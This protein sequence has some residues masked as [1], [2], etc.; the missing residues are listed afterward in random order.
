M[1]SSLATIVLMPAAA[2]ALVIIDKMFCSLN[3][4]V[5]NKLKAAPAA[6]TYCSSYLS[7]STQTKTSTVYVT[8][9]PVTNTKS[10]TLT[11]AP[12]TNVKTDVEHTTITQTTT[13]T[14]TKT[15][16]ATSTSTTST[17]TLSCLSSAYIAPTA[18]VVKRTFNNGNDVIVSAILPNTWVKSQVSAACSCLS[19]AT[20]TTT[21]TSSSTLAT[22]TVTVTNTAYSTPI[23][24]VTT[25]TVAT[26]I[27]TSTV[28]QTTTTT[29]T[30]TVYAVATA[31]VS[32]NL[33]YRQYTHTFNADTIVTGFT[34]AYFQGI[35]SKSSG[36][37]P[38]LNFATAA[39][40]VL[41]LSDSN[42]FVATQ[43][44]MVFNGFF[45]AQ[46]TGTYTLA[47]SNDYIDN[48]GYLWTGD[49][50]YAWADSTTAYQAKRVKSGYVGGSTT[51]TLNKGDA[52]PMTFLWANGG[53]IGRSQIWITTPSGQIVT[54]TTG[55]FVQACSSSIFT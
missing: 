2:S 25:T 41:T 51:V 16:T 19:I 27:A 43:A 12:V 9:T 33:S 26:S 52:I 23:V 14:T 30:Q 45:I 53:G 39:S 4:I 11:V 20:P 35:S 55:Y 7:I 34:A 5:I 8:P 31:I 32:N 1:R 48:W 29:T 10:I 38:D 47:S 17:T 24:D 13:Q 28:T 6:S 21:I 49:S 46:A 15:E 42:S 18:A 40:Q 54:S 36:S 50:A 22:V 44:A 3:I 37:I